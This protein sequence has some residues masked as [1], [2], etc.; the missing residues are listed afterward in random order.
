MLIL[1]P[2][3]EQRRTSFSATVE[4]VIVDKESR[5]LGLVVIAV[6]MK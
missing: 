2:I 3:E 1:E 4:K 5:T 6:L